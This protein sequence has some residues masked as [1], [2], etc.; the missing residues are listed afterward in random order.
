MS[1]K[2]S[3]YGT[4]QIGGQER[5]FHVGTNQGDVFQRLRGISLKEYG[6]LFS[7]QNLQELNLKGGDIA[8]FVYSALIAGAEYDGL[9][10]DF[11]HI[12]VR[13]WLD[14]AD[15]QEGSK[16]IGEMLNQA[17]ERAKRAAERAGNGPAPLKAT[18]GGKNAKKPAA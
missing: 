4:M 15:P 5:P 14:D 2:P 7:P 3:G 16:P 18:K 1:A 8:D 9:R 11:N 17:V 10:V 13:A 12:H 6:E